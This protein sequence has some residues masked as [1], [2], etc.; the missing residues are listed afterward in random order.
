MHQRIARLAPSGRVPALDFAHAVQD[1]LPEIAQHDERALFHR[2]LVEHFPD[3][4]E[5]HERASAAFA[6]DVAVAEAHEFKQALLPGGYASF[7]FHPTI[8][9]RAKKTGRYGE[10]A[11]AGFA[12]AARHGFHHAA[13]A[14]GADCKSC[15]RE[16]A[17]EFQGF[18]IVRMPIL[19]T[20]TSEHGDDF[21][22]PGHVVVTL[23]GLKAPIVANRMS[24]LKPPPTR[25]S[26]SLCST[27]TLGCAS[28]Y[29]STNLYVSGD[30]KARTANSGCATKTAPI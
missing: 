19:G 17:P 18:H 11:S 6:S 2:F 10:D 12:R 21:C 9:A 15:R 27:T 16:R 14:S 29:K 1:R 20:R 3:D 26:E 5:F 7:F 8:C 30:R 4:G 22:F 24:R 23:Q 28:F 13:V 25:H